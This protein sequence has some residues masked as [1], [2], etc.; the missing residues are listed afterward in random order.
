M[1]LD[2]SEASDLGMTCLSTVLLLF[3]LHY[4]YKNILFSKREKGYTCY[5]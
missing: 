1:C 4:S 5:K 2:L 3:I